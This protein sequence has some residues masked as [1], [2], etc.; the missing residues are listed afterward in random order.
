MR[1]TLLYLHQYAICVERLGN[2]Q[3]AIR[4]MTEVFDARTKLFGA[5]H[6][7]TVYSAKWLTKWNATEEGE[8]A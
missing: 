3:E 6:P 1:D 5:D 2:K 4:L 7:H 8:G